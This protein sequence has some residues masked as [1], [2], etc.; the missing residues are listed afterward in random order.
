MP[1]EGKWVIEHCGEFLNINGPRPRWVKKAE[2]ATR[3]PNRR[4]AERD[5]ERRGWG[6]GPT[7]PLPINA[8]G[9]VDFQH[10]DEEEGR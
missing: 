8:A 5:I 10:Q 3:Y 2:E 6:R 4:W 1:T 9:V 7:R